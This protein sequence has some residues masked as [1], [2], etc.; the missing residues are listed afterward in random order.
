[1]EYI[2]E[3]GKNQ[4]DKIPLDTSIPRTERF[5]NDPYRANTYII[6]TKEPINAETPTKLLIDY[7]YTPDK[8]FYNRNH[9]PI[10]DLKED[11]YFVEFSGELKQTG[12]ISLEDLKKMKK[13][14]VEAMMMCTG[15]RRSEFAEKYKKAAG[16][17]WKG[18]SV[19]NGVWGGVS[20]RDVMEKYFQPT[21]KAYHVEFIGGGQ[22]D[23]ADKYETSIPLEKAYDYD[24]IL[25]YEINGQPLSRDRGFPLRVIVP[26]YTG[27]R[28]VKW[29]SQINFRVNESQ[30]SHHQFDYKLFLPTM[31]LSKV[32]KADWLKAETIKEVNIN[33]YICNVTEG[34]VIQTPFI[35][36]GYAYCSGN[37]IWRIDF[38][39]D[40]GKT[41]TQATILKNPLHTD[42]QTKYYGWTLW[43]YKLEEVK[44]N[45]NMQL[46]VRAFDTVLNTQPLEIE[47]IWN[48]RGFMNNSV[49]RVNVTASS[50]SLNNTKF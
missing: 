45:Q 36:K 39:I 49:H 13:R 50:K 41:W 2:S 32:T 9:S 22:Q 21:D 28:M 12:K 42:K 38:S 40:G 27:A 47:N 6:H 10:L 37:K 11:N 46:C 15:N 35:V 19:G 34:D 33:S 20:L 16:L 26:G 5:K 24:V 3:H 30:S 1:M 18:G 43:E 48:F 25:C 14:T 7:R 31:E 4:L 29:L 23:S 8:L 44:S 17:S